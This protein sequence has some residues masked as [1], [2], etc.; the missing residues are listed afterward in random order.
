MVSIARSTEEVERYL[1]AVRRASALYRYRGVME[2]IAQ[3]FRDP[4]GPH[5]GYLRCSSMQPSG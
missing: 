3:F 4:F 5:G 2:Q 1:Q